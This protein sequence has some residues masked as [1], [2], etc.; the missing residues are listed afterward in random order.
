MK[1]LLALTVSFIL[2][3][4][5]GA[6]LLAVPKAQE[7]KAPTEK[8]SQTTIEKKSET[9]TEK[10]TPSATETKEPAAK[11]G[12]KAGK[13][14]RA[15]GRIVSLSDKEVTVEGKGK[16]TDNKWTFAVNETT[17]KPADLKEGSEVTVWYKEEAGQKVATK[18]TSKAEKGRPRARKTT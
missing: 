13:A 16:G 5:L 10:T 18:I 14:H 3:F 17:Q 4:A 1:K 11:Q 7:T 12:M 2:V 9:T 15:S 8:K 6:S